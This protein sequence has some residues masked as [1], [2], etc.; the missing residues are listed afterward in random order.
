MLEEFGSGGFEISL[1]H[2]DGK[3][4]VIPVLITK[5][6]G[7]W[8][9]IVERVDICMLKILDEAGFALEELCVIVTGQGLTVLVDLARLVDSIVI[10]FITWIGRSTA[11]CRLHA[12]IGISAVHT[13]HEFLGVFHDRLHRSH[14]GVEE[15]LRCFVAL[16]CIFIL[17]FV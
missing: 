17:V 1:I 5:T 16:G 8:L 9:A 3:F 11:L 13:I 10:V 14:L 4:C 15:K 2:S 6:I 12:T 7:L